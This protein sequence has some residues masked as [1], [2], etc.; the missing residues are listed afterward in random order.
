[1]ADN[2]NEVEGT[3][4]AV[5]SSPASS[6]K[7]PE[8]TNFLRKKVVR[9]RPVIRAKQWEKLL[10]MQRRDAYMYNSSKRTYTLP[11]S[12]RSG[13]L[14]ALLDNT[15]PK[16]TVQYPDKEMTEQKFF[17]LE[18]NKNLNLYNHKAENFWYTDKLSKITIGKDGIELDLGTALGMLRYKILLANKILIAPTRE[19][20]ESIPTYEFYVEDAEQVRETEFDFANK[21]MEAFSIFNDAKDDAKKLASFLK[22][23]NK[24]VNR[25]ATLPWLR[26]EVYKIVEAN[27]ESFLIA[28][29][30]PLFEDKA[31]VYDAVTAGAIVR[32]GR[33]E[34]G[35]DT[36][37]ILGN[38]NA[39]IAYLNK[40]ENSAMYN[41][42]RERVNR[43]A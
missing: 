23:C 30:D 36:G 1:M 13:S 11:V 6:F 10:E 7:K 4:K 39:T 41:I 22:A 15:T 3:E 32:K 35:L 21:K 18:L 27:P 37:T 40:P 34:F 8:L 43:A 25:N 38:I 5:M 19:I 14:V 17:E 12:G 31:F 42:I 28:V 16:V 29:Q 24:G 2:L 33:E 20:A 9:I 26:G